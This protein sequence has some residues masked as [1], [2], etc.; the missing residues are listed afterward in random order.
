MYKSKY[1]DS[2]EMR[3][4]RRLLNISCKDHKTREEVRNGIRDATGVHDDL[5]PLVKM[6]K[7]TRY[8]VSRSCG[9]S[10]TILKGTVKDQ[11]EKCRRSDG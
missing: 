10:K 4:Y 5:L 3:S 9:M 7:L 11:G 8:A 2:L 1:S 6:L